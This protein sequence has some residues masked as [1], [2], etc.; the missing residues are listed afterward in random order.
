MEDGLLRYDSNRRAALWVIN[1]ISTLGS[2]CHPAPFCSSCPPRLVTSISSSREDLLL[3]FFLCFNLSSSLLRRR[4]LGAGCA[5]AS[6]AL[7]RGDAGPGLSLPCSSSLLL[8]AARASAA[9]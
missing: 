8:E 2:K 6:W 4:D 9:L 7:E 1:P 5:L 3:C